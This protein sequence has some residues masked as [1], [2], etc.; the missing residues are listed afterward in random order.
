MKEST[1][2]PSPAAVY[3]DLE[4]ARVGGRSLLLDLYLSGRRDHPRPLVIWVHGGAW[5][6]GDKNE[7]TAL[8]L[9]EFGF[10][11]ACIDYRLSPAAIFP[12]QIHDCKAAVRWLR[13]NSEKYGLDPERIGA[14]GS[15]AG[16]HLVA[17]LGTSGGI[18]ELEG[19]VGGNLHYASRVQ[20]VCDWFGP[21]DL[22]Q[23]DAHAR[24]GSWIVHNTPDSPESQLIGCPIQENRE[25]AAKANPIAYIRRSELPPFLIMH[26]DRDDTVPFH[27]SILLYEALR[28]A[29]AEVEFTTVD[30]AGHG[31]EGDEVIDRVERFFIKHLQKERRGHP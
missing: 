5:L 7:D 24:P 8:P 31:F 29:G 28:Q 18:G 20:A 22:L 6:V 16:G 19:D 21:T 1:T 13:T 26:G 4:Y 9:L 30:G 15:S 3:R 27:Q 2:T 12:A 25:K 14:W 17:L 11:V 10:A 23:M